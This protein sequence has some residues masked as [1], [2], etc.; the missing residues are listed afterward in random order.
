[1]EAGGYANCKWSAN[2]QVSELSI[3]SEGRCAECAE[4]HRSVGSIIYCH[5]LIVTLASAST[6]T[7]TT[8][9]AT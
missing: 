9:S 5:P 4:R 6:A 7:P 3:T 1:M 8:L 2:I